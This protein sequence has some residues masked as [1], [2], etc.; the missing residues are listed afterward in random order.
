MGH[1]GFTPQSVN[2]LGFKVQ[3]KS[4]KHGRKLLSDAKKLE[5]AGCF[6]LVLELV[7]P[8]LAQSIA[9]AVKIPVIGIGAGPGLD[10]QVLVTHDI[11][12]LYP[13]PPA[14]VKKQADLG[15]VISRVAKKFIMSL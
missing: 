12:G 4:K 13:N 1:L 6:A 14:F 15:L 10:G 2:Q 3:G 8:K 11:I 9:R 7:P 5:Q